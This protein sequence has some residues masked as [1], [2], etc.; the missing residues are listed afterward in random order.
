MP[1]TTQM[2]NFWK[3]ELRSKLLIDFSRYQNEY[4][5]GKGEILNG[6]EVQVPCNRV[7]GLKIDENVVSE[8][9]FAIMLKHTQLNRPV[10]II[11]V[12]IKDFPHP[13]P[14][15]HY[16]MLY[17]LKDGKWHYNITDFKG[18]DSDYFYLETKFDSSFK[19]W[20]YLISKDNLP[21]E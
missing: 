15:S 3:S 5:K 10:I 19:E 13:K 4:L 12:S 8:Y 18:D 21:L 1:P 6:D 7:F 9:G 14:L 16:E 17:N 2:L 20:G 11:G